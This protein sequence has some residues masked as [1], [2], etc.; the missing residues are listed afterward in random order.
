MRVVVTGGSGFIGAN[1]VRYWMNAHPDDQIVNID[2]LTY[3]ANQSSLDEFAGDPR[4]S[5]ERVDITD[6][7]QIDLVFARNR[8]ELV[9][10]FAA[11]SHVDRSIAD[12]SIFVRTN[13]VGT[14]VLLDAAL[15]HNVSRFHHISTDEVFGA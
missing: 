14:Q 11:E 6:V 12:R 3:A 15:R 1:F 10:H 2:K 13:V 8:T 9:V 5:F 4:Y 7:D